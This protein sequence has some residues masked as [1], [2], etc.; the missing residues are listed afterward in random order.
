MSKKSIIPI[1]VAVCIVVITT[2]CLTFAFW[3][4]YSLKACDCIMVKVYQK[5]ITLTTEDKNF[6]EM[7]Q[8][9]KKTLNSSR[10]NIVFSKDQVKMQCNDKNVDD[11]K[12][13]N[14]IWIEISASNG[15]YHKLFFAINE[16][17]E[18][19][20]IMVFATQSESYDNGTFL[21]FNNCD[22]KQ[23]IKLLLSM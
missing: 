15:K 11:Y 5:S 22:C 1:T 18:K 4:P 6:E 17:E 14:D 23:L 13:S 10:F 7:K 12:T 9:I 3:R 20:F 2:I 19:Q 8:F 21:L 16:F